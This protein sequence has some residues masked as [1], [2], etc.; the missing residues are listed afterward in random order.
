MFKGVVVH[1]VSKN[2]T[3]NEIKAIRKQYNDSN[4]R[5]IVVVSGGDDIMDNLKY[6]IKA[7]AI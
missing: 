3:Q 6:F 2:T 4:K 1:Y 5:V 7:R